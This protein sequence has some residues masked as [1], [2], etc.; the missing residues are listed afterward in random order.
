MKDVILSNLG[1]QEGWFPFGYLGVPSFRGIPRKA[2]LQPLAD[3]AKARLA[4]WKWKL[5]S[6]G[7]RLLLIKAVF[8]SLLLHSFM[9]Y[10]WPRSPICQL[11]SYVCNFC[12]V[13]MFLLG[14]LWPLLRI[15]FVFPFLKVGWVFGNLVL[16]I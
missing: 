8:Q 2:H 7:G 1:F 3:R 4:S 5:L 15:R 11:N 14:M 9:I 10:L 6:M 13:V 12:G 16:S